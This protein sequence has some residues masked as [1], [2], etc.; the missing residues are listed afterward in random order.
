MADAIKFLLH[1]DV[2]SDEEID[3]QKK[4][5]IERIGN[6]CKAE[7]IPFFSKYYLMMKKLQIILVW[8]LP[9]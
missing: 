1:Y 8:N 5:Y 2:D 9:K 7:D 6:E 3:L 4:V